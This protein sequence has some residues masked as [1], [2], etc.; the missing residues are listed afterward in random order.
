MMHSVLH[1][2]IN[3]VDPV[4]FV[5]VFIQNGLYDQMHST[6][7]THAA[8][9]SIDSLHTMP[10]WSMCLAYCQHIFSCFKSCLYVAIRVAFPLPF[11]TSL[12]CY[13]AAVTV[14]VGFRIT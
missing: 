13:A 3:S 14:F 9:C 8:N 2:L 11:S 1:G 10:T 4:L 12:S 5:T 6:W 7:Y